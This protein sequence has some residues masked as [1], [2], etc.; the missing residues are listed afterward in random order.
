[1]STRYSS[2]SSFS[3]FRTLPP[4]FLSPIL[5]FE[6]NRTVRSKTDY[7]INE[8]ISPRGNFVRIFPPRGEIRSVQLIR[9]I[10]GKL[11]KTVEFHLRILDAKIY[12]S[13]SKFQNPR[14][15]F[16]PLRLGWLTHIFWKE[17]SRVRDRW[18]SFSSTRFPEAARSKTARHDLT[19]VV[20]CSRVKQL[21]SLH[22][23]PTTHGHERSIPV[24]LALYC[25]II[26][27]P[28]A[29]ARVGLRTWPVKA[30]TSPDNKRIASS[31]LLFWIFD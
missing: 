23:R 6:A 26:I 7:L 30:S 19:W 21:T 1:M 16:I 27:H 15:K 28:P 18:P 9:D 13:R 29:G 22:S 14:N 8:W 4:L 20:Q 25:S 31:R 2:K 24:H 10:R 3:E 11:W 12:K 5:E 17:R